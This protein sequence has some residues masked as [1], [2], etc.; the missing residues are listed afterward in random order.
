MPSPPFVTLPGDVP[1]MRLLPRHV[2]CCDSVRFSV[3]LKGA[4][5]LV[6]L[7]KGLSDIT[8][9][10]LTVT[11]KWTVVLLAFPDDGPICYFDAICLRHSIF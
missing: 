6:F 10:S 1:K 5:N 7:C 9:L 11:L 3:K 2:N 8:Q 4:K